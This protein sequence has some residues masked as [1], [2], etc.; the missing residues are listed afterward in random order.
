M[1]WRSC[2]PSAH[3]VIRDAD[4][5]PVEITVIAEACPFV[6]QLCSTSTAFPWRLFRGYTL[7][8]F[9]SSAY[10]IADITTSPT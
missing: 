3:D 9:S 4:A 2:S 5:R 6:T 8:Q 1:P 10:V 7:S